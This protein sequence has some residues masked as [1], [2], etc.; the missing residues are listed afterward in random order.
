MRYRDMQHGGCR[1]HGK[2]L[3]PV[4]EHKQQIRTQLAK[5]SRHIGKM[6]THSHSSVYLA[7]RCITH[8]HECRRLKSVITYL[9]D[10]HAPRLVE[11][12]IGRNDTQSDTVAPP[13]LFGYRRE[14]TPVGSRRTD[15]RYMSRFYSCFHNY[16]TKLTVFLL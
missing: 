4:A 3:E 9:A 16:S 13:Q 7:V 11:M 10:R 12:H 2:H 5:R 15:Y 14:Q 8:R 6:L 1:R